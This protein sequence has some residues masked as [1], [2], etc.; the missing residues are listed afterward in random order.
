MDLHELLNDGEQ[1]RIQRDNHNNNQL[2]AIQ[3]PSAGSSSVG[4]TKA[5]PDATSP[6][7]P[8]ASSIGTIRRER[9]VPNGRSPLYITTSS[10]QD[11]DLE[12][13]AVEKDQAIEVST[14][15]QRAFQSRIS[16]PTR[17]DCD[18][19]NSKYRIAISHMSN[20]LANGAPTSASMTPPASVT[21]SN[22]SLSAADTKTT[23]N[24][25]KHLITRRRL[26]C[27]VCGRTDVEEHLRDHQNSPYCVDHRTFKE[28]YASVVLG[29]NTTSCMEDLRKFDE[30]YGCFEDYSFG[31]NVDTMALLVALKPEREDRLREVDESAA[32]FGSALPE[33]RSLLR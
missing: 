13:L 19:M 31:P 17:S 29:C 8:T 7:T 3:T 4:S 32:E 10:S 23:W 15:K 22:T 2:H 6:R 27:S 25:A 28:M 9:K 14:A 21:I 30:A 16:T 5:V 12:G 24:G 20:Q 11:A 33:T 18:S 26:Q 1:V